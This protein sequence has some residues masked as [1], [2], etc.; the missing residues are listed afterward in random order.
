MVQFATSA[1]VLNAIS[2]N[3]E[4]MATVPGKKQ[5]TIAPKECTEM[6]PAPNWSRYVRAE[7]FHPLTIRVWDIDPLIKLANGD[8][9]RKM[10]VEEA[11]RLALAFEQFYGNHKGKGRGWV[12]K[13]FQDWIQ[14]LCSGDSKGFLWDWSACLTQKSLSQIVDMLASEAGVVIAVWYSEPEKQVNIFPTRKS[15]ATRVF[16]IDAKSG[17]LLLPEVSSSTDIGGLQNLILK[18]GASFIPARHISMNKTAAE[19]KDELAR[20]TNLP[21]DIIT[22]MSRTTLWQEIER[23]RTFD[24][25]SEVAD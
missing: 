2:K 13:T 5:V 1:E 23:H 8:L 16:H 24:L 12:K 6:Y 17:Q 25:D 14:F 22:K 11:N 10:L 20:I 21:P 15:A 4:R 19:M 9:L 3:P 18:S 7:V